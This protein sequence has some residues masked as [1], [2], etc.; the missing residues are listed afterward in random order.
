M[1]YSRLKESLKDYPEKEENFNTIIQ[2]LQR[3]FFPSCDECSKEF[4]RGEKILTKDFY[5]PA[6]K[7]D[8]CM[9]CSEGKDLESF[10]FNTAQ[11]INK[12]YII[13]IFAVKF[14]FDELMLMRGLEVIE[15]A[16]KY[17]QGIASAREVEIIEKLKN[18]GL[19]N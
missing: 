18:F 19:L 13:D 5:G 15:M 8:Y 6:F 7:I 2:Y 17:N 10:F 11:P 3:D 12:Q 14:T 4:S 9:K 16:E 1:D